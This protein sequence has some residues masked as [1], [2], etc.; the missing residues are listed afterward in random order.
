MAEIPLGFA[1]CAA[2]E[3][4]PGNRI[5]R[6]PRGFTQRHAEPEKIFG[7]HEIN[8]LPVKCVF[9]PWNL[10]HLTKAAAGLAVEIGVGKWTA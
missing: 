1:K 9:L 3:D 6:A 10:R 4:E 8:Q 7:V 5:R 2:A